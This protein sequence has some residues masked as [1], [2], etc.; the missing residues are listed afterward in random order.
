MP[1]KNRG[2]G[3]V[4]NQIINQIYTLGLNYTKNNETQLQRKFL[5]N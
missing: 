5:Q 2:G 3:E 4:E 1:K